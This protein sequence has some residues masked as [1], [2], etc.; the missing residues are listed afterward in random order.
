MYI[1]TCLRFE[2]DLIC[3]QQSPCVVRSR[4]PRRCPSYTNALTTSHVMAAPYAG[5]VNGNTVNIYYGL[6]VFSPSPEHHLNCSAI[7]PYKNTYLPHQK[8]PFHRLKVC[9]WVS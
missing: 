4:T 3:V 6:S 8:S 5:L 7:S 9:F 2:C 1:N